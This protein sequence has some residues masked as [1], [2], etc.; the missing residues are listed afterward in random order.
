M[1]TNKPTQITP[2]DSRDHD[3][4][5]RNRF[6]AGKQMKAEEFTI[7]QR[8]QIGRRR[9]L[10]RSVLGWGVVA[11]FGLTLRKAG[12]SA[13]AKLELAPG[14]ALDRHGRELELRAT[15]W[16]SPANLLLLSDDACRVQ[17]LGKLEHGRYVLAAH[18]AERRVGDANLR[19]GC[20][21]E[22]PE[23]NFVCE[24]IV[25]SLRRLQE[26]PCPCGDAECSRSCACS[27]SSSCPPGRGPH[28]C[29]SRWLE[30]IELEGDGPGLCEWQGLYVAMA[31]VDL[32]CLVVGPTEDRC[33][34]FQVEALDDDCSPRRLVKSNDLL[35]DLLRG[36]DLTRITNVSWSNWLQ[37]PPKD[38]AWADFAAMFRD[39]SD[40]KYETKADGRTGFTLDFSRPVQLD[41]LLA[42]AVVMTVCTVEQ[43]TGWRLV[44]RVPIVELRS[45]PIGAELPAGTT[46]RVRVY[47]KA[48]WVR[49]ELRGDRESWLSERKFHVE[50]EVRGDLILDC[51]GQAVDANAISNRLPS[52]NG[53]PGG[54]YLSTFR[55]SAKPVD[56]LE[57]EG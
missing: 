15:T 55:V 9:L 17:A 33:L 2:S 23:K 28:A 53:T 43:S 47:V 36:C 50:I 10:N 38:V 37:R 49:D 56:K 45:E 34:P 19:E 12:E 26:A 44:R 41:T 32:A 11:G 13:I 52:G 57:A 30:A 7:E 54:T 25:F 16:L 6:F 46:D 31:A 48:S 22:E 24:T 4:G 5:M 29:L 18:Y 40:S 3:D 21:C 27:C 1:Q 51:H 14:L 20:G 39:E 35:F 42:D 8:Y